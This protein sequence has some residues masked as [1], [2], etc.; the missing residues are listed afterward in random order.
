MMFSLAWVHS[1]EMCLV[2]GGNIAI[3]GH[4]GEALWK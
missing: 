3:C 1:I 4:T 2:E